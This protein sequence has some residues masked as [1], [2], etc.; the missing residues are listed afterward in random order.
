MNRIALLCGMKAKIIVLLLAQFWVFI[1]ALDAQIVCLPN[2]HAHN[3]YEHNRPLM[4][5]LSH[6]FT[7]VE[8]DIHLIEGAI[9]V[10]HN[11]PL[12]KS[13]KILL[14]QLYLKPLEAIVKKNGGSVYP[15]CD[16]TFYLMIDIKT[17]AESTYQALQALLERYESML[18]TVQGAYRI[19]GAVTIFLSGNRPINTVLETPKRLAGIDGRP[20]DIGKGY[21]AAFMPVISDNYNNH[22]RWRGNGT[23]PVEDLEKLQTWV[24]MAHA[25]GKKVRLWASPDQPIVWETLLN[26]G[27]DLLN[28]DDL[29][30]LSDYLLQL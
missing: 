11:R 13:K 29:K 23:P 21:S 12:K 25:E 2:A 19:E 18:T 1:F 9:Y 20:S 24:A 10:S 5:A 14:E 15:N 28:A 22:L 26:L 16:S 27:V 3:D 8:A 30:G 17:E 4:D 6:G 7:S